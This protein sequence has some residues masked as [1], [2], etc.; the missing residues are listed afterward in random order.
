M[1][2]GPDAELMSLGKDGAS[3]GDDGGGLSSGVGLGSRLELSSG[4]E[5]GLGV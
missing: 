2:L 5:L 4:V 1:S 3:S